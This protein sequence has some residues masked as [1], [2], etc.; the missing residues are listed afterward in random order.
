MI[1]L[2]EHIT[3]AQAGKKASLESIKLGSD[4]SHGKIWV[5]SSNWTQQKG[6][7]TNK[8]ETRQNVENDTVDIGRDTSGNDLVE[9]PTS[10]RKKR[11]AKKV[12]GRKEEGTTVGPRKAS[13]KCL[14]AEISRWDEIRGH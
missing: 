10:Q 14:E 5:I 9:A 11:K 8:T 1:I 6:H 7:E 4:G 3:M 2:L 13:N 12:L